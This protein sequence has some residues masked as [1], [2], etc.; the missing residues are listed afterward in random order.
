MPTDIR[1]ALF[2]TIERHVQMRIV[3]VDALVDDLL[4]TF[5]QH[6]GEGR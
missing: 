6:V 1:K 4:L 5:Q 3:E 2:D